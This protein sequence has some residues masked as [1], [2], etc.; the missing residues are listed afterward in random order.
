MKKMVNIYNTLDI[1]AY[2]SKVAP[3]YETT[4]EKKF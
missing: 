3:C 4:Y 1:G 2:N